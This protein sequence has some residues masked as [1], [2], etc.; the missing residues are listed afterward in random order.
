MTSFSAW[1]VHWTRSPGTEAEIIQNL[2]GVSA[3]RTFETL[4]FVKG[5]QIATPGELQILY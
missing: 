4:A 3:L 1:N 5:V 2:V